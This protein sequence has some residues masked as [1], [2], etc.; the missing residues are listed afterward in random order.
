MIYPSPEINIKINKSSNVFNLIL[1]HI[2]THN[3]HFNN[4]KYNLKIKLIQLLINN[5]NKCKCSKTLYK[6]NNNNNRCN[7]NNNRCNSNKSNK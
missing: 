1:K 6:Y 3:F 4:K 2:Q 7:S 5:N